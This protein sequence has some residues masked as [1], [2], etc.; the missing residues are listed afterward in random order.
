MDIDAGW[1]ASQSPAL[2]QCLRRA[3]LV[4]VTRRDHE[5]LPAD[6]I[7]GIGLGE[8]G[9]PALI[10]KSGP[11]GVTVLANGESVALPA[12]VVQQPIRTDIGAGDLLLGL[13]SARIALHS[14][15]AF[16]ETIE[17]AYREACPVVAQ[18][19]Q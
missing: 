7:A 5:R 9:G 1:A 3:Q 16:L 17:G 10:I 15:P 19:L 14:R 8:P 18:L 12:P 4:T 6:C 11:A 13:L 2:R